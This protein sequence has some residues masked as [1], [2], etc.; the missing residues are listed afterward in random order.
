MDRHTQLFV[1]VKESIFGFDVTVSRSTT[2]S[3]TTR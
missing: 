2:D 3:D 1:L